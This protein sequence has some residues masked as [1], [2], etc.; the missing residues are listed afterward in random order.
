MP[1]SEAA[2]AWP[3]KILPKILRLTSKTTATTYSF[4]CDGSFSGWACCTVNDVTGELGIQSDWGSW[5][6]RWSTA[7]LGCPSL[8]HFLGDRGSVNYMARKLNGDGQ[9]F[10]AKASRDA[11]RARICERRLEDGRLE[12]HHPQR[13]LLSKEEARDCWDQLGDIANDCGNN[14]LDIFVQQLYQID[15]FGKVTEEPHYHLAT[16]QTSADRALRE[17]VLPALIEACAAEVARRG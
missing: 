3:P 4:C 11:L 7:S 16:E 10:S 2:K 12:R 13:Q 9:A 6:Y 1:T 14:S 5:S 17:I 15:G 8:T